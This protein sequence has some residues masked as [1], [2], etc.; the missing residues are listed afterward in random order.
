LRC[1][2]DSLIFLKTYIPP[3]DRWMIST[4]IIEVENEKIISIYPNPA[5][6]KLSINSKKTFDHIE[7]L[8]AQGQIL[9]SLTINNNTI[10]VSGL[11]KGLYLL[12]IVCKEGVITKKFIKY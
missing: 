2:H 5:N 9:K 1:Y 4:S 11:S 12:R 6:D 8:T 7:I 10:D 3:C